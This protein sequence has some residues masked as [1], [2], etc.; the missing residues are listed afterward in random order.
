MESESLNLFF[1]RIIRP[2]THVCI[3]A[4]IVGYVWPT[5]APAHVWCLNMLPLWFTSI[6]TWTWIVS[7][8]G[9]ILTSFRLDN[10]TTNVFVERLNSCWLIS[11]WCHIVAIT[12]SS[13]WRFWGLVYLST[14]QTIFCEIWILF[15]CSWSWSCFNSRLTPLSESNCS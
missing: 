13:L 8:W 6:L 9:W 7:H 15:I 12:W 10:S 3:I 2:W 1:W 14:F 4:W 11:S 5:F